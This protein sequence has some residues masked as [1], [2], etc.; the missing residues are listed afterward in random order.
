MDT[1]LLINE[2]KLSKE[3]KDNQYSSDSL[4]LHE[5]V[6]ILESELDTHKNSYRYIY[7]EKFIY[8]FIV[9]NIAIMSF[10]YLK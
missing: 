1:K 5:L 7:A 6:F 10:L 4:N 3:Y 2:L 8:I 9:M